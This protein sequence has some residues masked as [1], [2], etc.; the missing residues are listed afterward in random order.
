MQ[1]A[2]TAGQWAPGPALAARGGRRPPGSGLGSAV[3]PGASVA[4]RPP[5]PAVAVAMAPVPPVRPVRPVRPD[6]HPR[7][8]HRPTHPL[9]ALRALRALHGLRARRAHPRWALPVRVLPGGSAGSTVRPRPGWAARTGRGALPRS[10]RV[11]PRAGVPERGRPPP[12]AAWGRRLATGLSR[13]GSGR[14]RP[15]PRRDRWPRR[16]SPP[17]PAR[18]AAVGRSRAG[19]PH[20]GGT[21]SGWV[22]WHR[23]GSRPGGAGGRRRSRWCRHRAG[24]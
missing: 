10:H 19:P 2:P 23:A 5:G 6:A 21:R 14:G 11:G 15:I 7:E 20:R 22:G 8:A 1:V 9:G 17:A 13:P 18:R 3:A 4:P 24:P 16:T 12:R